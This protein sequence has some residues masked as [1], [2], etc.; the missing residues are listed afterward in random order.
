MVTMYLH[1]NPVK[2][3]Y[4]F[5]CSCQLAHV[6]C[7][8]CLKLN[9]FIKSELYFVASVER[10]ARR[11]RC[12]TKGKELEKLTKAMG[13]RLPIA[14]EDGNRR[15]H[16]P[17]QAAKFASEAGIIIRENM[18][19]LTHWK[20]YKKDTKKYYDKFVGELNV[21]TSLLFLW[22]PSAVLNLNLDN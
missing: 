10:A 15:P 14:V 19:I 9:H 3:S 12:A 4:S 13:R 11:P 20:Q 6:F 16:E 8:F 7:C 1:V 17:V 18:P 2:A 22:L 21:S 5:S